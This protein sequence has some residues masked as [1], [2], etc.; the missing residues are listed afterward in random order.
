MESSFWA[1]TMHYVLAWV[2]NMG[3]QF[4]IV[5]LLIYLKNSEVLICHRGLRSGIMTAAAW[6]A[7]VVQVQSLVR[8]IPHA[9]NV[10]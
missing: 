4:A 10:A 6:V 1:V 8:E 5:T 2:G 9:M 3:A 7:A